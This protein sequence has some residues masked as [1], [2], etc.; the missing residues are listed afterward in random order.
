MKKLFFLSL[1][2]FFIAT[3]CDDNTDTL[4]SSLTNKEDVIKVSEGVFK[5]VSRSTK[6]DSV[7]S[8]NTTGYLGRVKDPETG[9]YIQSDFLT[10]F[11]VPE[12]FKLAE[13][14]EYAYGVV[15]DSCDLRL[16]FNSFYGDSLTSMKATVYELSKPIEENTKYYSSFDPEKHDMIRIGEGS[17]TS[18]RIFSL[19][20]QNYSDSIRNSS[21]YTNNI[22][23]R[24]NNEYVD[25]DGVRYNNYG[26]YLMK[27]YY[28]DKDNYKNSYNFSHNVC[29]GFYVHF[30][31][32]I[33]AMAY[34]SSSQI[35][36]YYTTEDT[37]KH[38]R[39]TS[40]AGTEEV[41]QITRIKNDDTRLEE[42]LAD[43]SCTYLKSPAGLQ[44]ELTIPVEDICRGHEN[45]SINGAKIV[46]RS[47]NNNVDS[48][49]SFAAPNTVL[50]VR[51]SEMKEF[52]EENRLP[53]Y[54]TSFIATYSSTDGTYTFGN[55]SRAIGAMFNELPA[56]ASQRETWKEKNPD[57]NKMVIVPVDAQYTSY[58][59]SYYGETSILT[60][61]THDMSLKSVRLVGGENNPYADIEISIIYC[62]FNE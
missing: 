33:G 44:T 37:I 47:L 35:S 56:D 21:S 20:D 51:K 19:S 59:S 10:Q 18:S 48:K 5:I 54:R 16:F 29:P 41:R 32:G 46:L 45:D 25:K 36:I 28:A 53:D 9:A 40:L 7:L 6:V 43:N 3:S 30:E 60:S 14:E 4:G 49:Y 50:L 31:N 24:L 22:H 26:T 8:R 17:V 61:V 12:N 13:V 39:Y 27:K 57:W 34:I 62:K 52:F 58:G 38:S 15:A 42:L 23:F 55:I 1:A 11:H 2:I